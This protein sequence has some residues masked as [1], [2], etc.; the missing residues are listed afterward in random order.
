MKGK[1]R[2]LSRGPSLDS[3]ES[4]Y[5]V[6]LYRDSVFFF[7]RAFLTR[8]QWLGRLGDHTLNKCC[9]VLYCIV[10][11][12]IVLYCMVWYGMVWY[13]MVWCGMVW[14]GMVWYGMVWYGMVWYGIKIRTEH[15][16]YGIIFKV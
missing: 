5:N 6:I 4:Y 16:W 9:I 12:C 11:Y 3:R 14:Y 1:V 7:S 2:T 13:G 8:A 10:L 15:H